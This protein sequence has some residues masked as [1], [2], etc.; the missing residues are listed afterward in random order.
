M[1]GTG[2]NV[3]GIR[4]LRDGVQPVELR[5]PVAL[6]QTVLAG[7]PLL[8]RGN[9]HHCA[10]SARRCGPSFGS[11][12]ASAEQCLHTAVR[13]MKERGA[14]AVKLEGGIE[15]LPQVEKLVL[16]GIPVMTHIGFTSQMEHQL[17]GYRVKG[18]TLDRQC[19]SV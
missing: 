16:S 18:A 5:P 3:A 12:Q 15:K 6:G 8:R 7:Q 19:Q 17:R 2:E 10:S 4:R 11:Y 14:H 9:Y 13:F 1:H